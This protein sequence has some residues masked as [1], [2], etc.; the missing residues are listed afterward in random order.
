[1]QRR[2]CLGLPVGCGWSME[3]C[4][5]KHGCS[6][7]RTGHALCAL[8]LAAQCDQLLQDDMCAFTTLVPLV[9]RMV[10]QG[11]I[12]SLRWAAPS[13][14]AR[15]HGAVHQ[16]SS[17]AMHNV[18]SHALVHC[19]PARASGST[20][21]CWALYAG[22]TGGLAGWALAEKRREA[23]GGLGPGAAAQLLAPSKALVLRTQAG[24]AAHTSSL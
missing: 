10:S 8:G 24:A 17:P 21:A 20:G 9:V 2:T 12:N 5:L 16:G 7:V 14:P 15:G 4:Q 23:R 3:G 22:S 6:G 1:M 19:G 11:H 13:A 18:A